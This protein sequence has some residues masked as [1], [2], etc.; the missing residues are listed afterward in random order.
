M[1][2]CVFPFVGSF[3][4]K[5]AKKPWPRKGTQVSHGSVRKLVTRAITH[6]LPGSIAAGNWNQ[7]PELGI[8]P[9][10]SDGGCRHVNHHLYYQAKRLSLELVVW[11]CRMASLQGKGISLGH[12]FRVLHKPTKTTDSVTGTENA[13]SGTSSLSTNDQFLKINNFNF[14]KSPVTEKEDEKV[15]FYP[16][17]YSPGS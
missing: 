1:C 12:N 5:A 11:L 16:L 14:L 9:R 3:P 8:K 10:F 7:K 15:F 2:V 13:I 17:A 4:Q 6:C